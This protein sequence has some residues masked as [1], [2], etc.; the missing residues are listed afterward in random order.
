MSEVVAYE[1]RP[2]QAAF[3][4]G[5]HHVQLALPKGGEDDCRN[6]YVGVLVS[7]KCRNHRCWR[8]VADSGFEPTILKSIWAP[9]RT[10]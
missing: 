3:G 1:S 7:Q 2:A 10:S 4:W 5:L 8:P 6:F 9:R